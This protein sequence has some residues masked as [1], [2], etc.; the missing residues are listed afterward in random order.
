MSHPITKPIKRIN[1]EDAR[2]KTATV[3]IKALTINAKQMTLSV[4][5]QIQEEP[6]I[7]TATMQLRGTPWGLINYFWK[8][9]EGEIHVLW[10]K[11]TELRRSLV[12]KKDYAAKYYYS[13][14]LEY[15][16]RLIHIESVYYDGRDYNVRLYH[17]SNNGGTIPYDFYSDVIRAFGYFNLWKEEMKLQNNRTHDRYWFYYRILIKTYKRMKKETSFADQYNEL[18]NQLSTLDQLFIAV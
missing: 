1:V 16:D 8:E 6:I 2:I 7:D 18:F 9:A 13:L 4:F 5:R 11:G 15:L 17:P 14:I 12:S 10:Q 3:E